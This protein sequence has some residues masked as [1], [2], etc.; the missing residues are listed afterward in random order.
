MAK[1]T[2][3]DEDRGASLPQA[4]E[5]DV[6]G[7]LS[8]TLQAHVLDG[9]SHGALEKLQT[10]LIALEQQEKTLSGWPDSASKA[11]ICAA[12]ATAR[13]AVSK[14]VADLARDRSGR[15]R[16]NIRAVKAM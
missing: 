10:L 5:S 16:A 12:L 14:I 6:L 7:F 9:E 2:T 3:A 11:R 1:A 15:E 4:A 13:T 8:R